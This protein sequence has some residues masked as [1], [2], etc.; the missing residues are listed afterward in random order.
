MGAGACVSAA[1][2]QQVPF[3]PP[4][5]VRARPGPLRCRTEAESHQRNAASPPG[6]RWDKTHTLRAGERA[7][8]GCSSHHFVG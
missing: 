7:V 5:A 6:R 1:D 2:A 3:W 4:V 8:G